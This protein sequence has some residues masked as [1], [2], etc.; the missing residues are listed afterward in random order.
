M[1]DDQQELIKR[2]STKDMDRFNKIEWDFSDNQL[3]IIEDAFTVLECETFKTIEA[4]DH[5]VII[6][7]VKNIQT[8]KKNPMLYHRRQ[9]G[10]IPSEFYTPTL[11]QK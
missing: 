5:T 1:A 11:N 4:G 8:D 10:S 3:P 7:T 2:F 6:G 9:I